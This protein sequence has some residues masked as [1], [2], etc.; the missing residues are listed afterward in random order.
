[1]ALKILSQYGK[2]HA[3]EKNNNKLGLFLTLSRLNKTYQNCIL[4]LGM[5]HI[6]ELREM[7]L[8]SQPNFIIIT[9][10]SP[11]HI[12]NFKSE[13]QIAITKSEIFIGLKKDI[14]F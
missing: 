6:N 3:T 8:I 1:M 7:S 5:N 10:V 4:E 14:F 2:T 12:G 11:S 13:K 9:N